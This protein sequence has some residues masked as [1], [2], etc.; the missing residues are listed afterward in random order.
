MEPNDGHPGP[1]R[2]A[3]PR[4]QLLSHVF[5]SAGRVEGRGVLHEVSKTG[6]RIEDTSPRLK[7]GTKVQLTFVLDQDGQPMDISANVVRET[8]SGFAVQFTETNERLELWFQEV[9]SRSER[10]DSRETDRSSPPR[11]AGPA[12]NTLRTPSQRPPGDAAKKTLGSD[13]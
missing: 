1:E 3:T 13:P 8:E 10:G 7:P 9:L 11:E 5:F 4:V 6:A 12:P 2:R